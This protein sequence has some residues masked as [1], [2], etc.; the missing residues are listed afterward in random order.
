[1]SATSIR[2]LAPAKINLFLHILGRR[3]DGYHELQ[4][5][6]QF[7]NL[8]DEIEINCRDD[9]KIRSTTP[10]S[11]ISPQDDLTVRA[12]YALRRLAGCNMGADI[13][14]RKVIPMGAGLGGGSSDCA[15]VLL[16]LNHLWG[17]QWPLDE[18]AALGGT[19]GAD[20][21]VFVRGKTAWGEGIGERLTPISLPQSWYLVVVPNCEVSTAAVFGAPSLTRNSTPMTIRAYFGAAGNAGDCEA[22]ILHLLNRTR[23]DCEAWV[24][25][26]YQPVDAAWR[27]A[28][29]AGP[30]RM[31]GTG[32][33]VFVPLRDEHQARRW[34]QLVPKSWRGFAARGLKQSPAL[35]QLERLGRR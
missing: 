9:G 11:G 28:S 10:I 30:V 8:C 21:P 3:E 6:F 35:G 33:A 18:L 31:T 1:V 19:L 13:S 12:A 34:A 7:L 23:N 24:R 15:T 25:E 29:E 26:R 2:W 22:D 16:A 20:V 4:T 5:A 32:A 14:V 27:W 17:L